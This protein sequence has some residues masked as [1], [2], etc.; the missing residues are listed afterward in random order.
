MR[1]V[2]LG[3]F[4]LLFHLLLICDAAAIGFVQVNA[5]VPQSP[6]SS[7]A[8]TY[9]SAQAAGDLNVVVVGW[10]DSTAAV[11]SVTDSKGNAYSLAVGPTI[12]PGLATQ[13]IY[14]AK[15]I[16]AAA[17]NGNTVK[18]LFNAPAA[19]P[20]IRILEYSGLDTVSPVDVTAAAAGSGAMSSSGPANT[21]NANDLLV[22][23]NLVQTTTRVQTTTSGPGTGFVTR[24]ITNPNGDIAEDRI[25]SA[26]GKYRADAPLTTPG[27][28]IMQLVAFKAAPAGAPTM[29]I[30]QAS[31]QADP[32]SV[33][34]INFTAVFS[35]PVTGFTGSDVVIGGTAGGPRSAVVTGSGAT[36]N[37]AISG[38]TS[39]GTVTVSIPANAAL[40]TAGRGNAASTS[41][42][43]SVTYTLIGPPP[44]TTPPDVAI[45]FPPD[46]AQV[47]DIVMVTADADD[48]VGVAGVQ[49]LLDGQN[50]GNEDTTAPYA[51]SW[52][53]RAVPNGAHTLTARARDTSG[54]T[55]L[56]TAVVVNVAN[57][58]LLQNEVLATGFTLPTCILFLPDARM[59]VVELQG[60]IKV[61]PPPYTTPSP[62]LFLQLSNVG[63]AGV[64]QGIYNIALDPNFASNRFYYLFYTAGTPNRD[65]LS[66]FTANASLTGTVAGSELILYQDPQDA[67]AEHH[68]GSINFGNDGKLYFTTGEHF[69]AAVAQF[70]TSPRGKIHRINPD[71]SVPVDNPFYDGNGPNWDSIWAIGMRNPFRAYYDAPTGRLIIGDVGGN[72]YSVANEEVDIGARAANFGWPNSEGPCTGVC[73][74]PIFFYPHNGRDACI[75]GGFVYHGTGFPSSYQG[76]YFFADYTQHWIRRLTMDASGTV[77]GVFNFEPPD[78]SVDG[79]YGDIVYLTEG[80]DGAIYYVDL[81][82][83]DISGTFGVS[84]IRRIRFVQ[85]NLPPIVVASATP[86]P[87]MM[88]MP[89]LFSSDGSYDPEQ[90]P[91]TYFWTFGDGDTSTEA[92]PIHLYTQPGQYTARLTVSDN[93]NTSLSPP[94]VIN[95]GNRPTATIALPLDGSHFIA[96]D[97]ISFSGSGTDQEDGAI[98][99][100][101][102]TWNIDFLHEGHVHPGIPITGVT[103]GSFVI[104]TSGHDFSG[105]TRYR[106]QLTVTDSDGLQDVKSVL[107]WPQK[108]NLSFASVPT[109]LTLSIDGVDHT[110]PFVHDTLVQFMHTIRA[111]DQSQGQN[112]CTFSSWSDGGAAQHVITVPATDHAYT[113]TYT[114]TQIP[115]PSGLVAGWSFNEGSGTTAHD[116]SG[117][118]NTVAL[119]SGT[120]WTAGHYN[121]GLSMTGTP[122]AGTPNSASLS[123]SGSY[124]L[125]AWI[126][127]S[128]LN[129]YQTVMVKEDPAGGGGCGY[130]LQTVGTAVSSG[131]NAGAGCREHT[132]NAGLQVNTWYH[133]AAVFD[134]AANT[135]SIYVNGVLQVIDPETAAPLPNNQRLTIGRSAFGEYW[136]G[137]LDEGR[138]YNRALAPGEVQVDM[139]TPLP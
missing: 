99:P 8:V 126:K 114:V 118:N 57:A 54:N 50:A 133:I 53:T 15:N 49:F 100:S 120:S 139:N 106:I 16:V 138:I 40:D 35:A 75:V 2:A 5:A 137:V 9:G 102:F 1:K 80:P 124:T 7:V 60:R 82:Y 131:F 90:Q 28:W 24:I 64:Q 105:N 110:A 29:T 88:P 123:L 62:T 96:G 134:N 30:N 122:S 87:N 43:N 26:A 132:A 129:G 119:V 72:D 45:T 73:T 22:G 136:N 44:D 98:P 77:T 48:N 83:S 78:G 18:V 55:A 69:D 115:I 31:G 85:S 91:I 52:D 3:L 59:L 20:D 81:G 4:W 67:N 117:N 25:V 39:G 42:D 61:L 92:N 84:K 79:P 33:S 127:P 38:M 27:P 111:P 51:Y 23:A 34:P 94:L 103:S 95:A 46:G 56:S 21:T 97:T 104:P 125:T 74:D 70:L 93:V 109:G 6:Q 128:S 89:V 41:T 101:G 135:Y 47:S 71:G 17:A 36:Y 68:G 66:R 108:V 37:V 12:Q 11:A 65:R 86:V 10:K 13:S 113:A 76:S 116:S 107:V 63:S 121:G 19:F 112:A 58:N 130:W 14:Y 32:T